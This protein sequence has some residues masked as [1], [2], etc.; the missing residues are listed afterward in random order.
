MTLLG[1]AIT[2]NGI[3]KTCLSHH[4]LSVIVPSG[5]GASSQLQ[6]LYM[7][8]IKSSRKQQTSGEGDLLRELLYDENKLPFP[9]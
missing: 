5:Q 1:T 2:V 7:E 8:A 3:A 9:V 4:S 6:V